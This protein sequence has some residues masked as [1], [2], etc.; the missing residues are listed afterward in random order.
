MTNLQCQSVPVYVS[1]MMYVHLKGCINHMH[2]VW[3]MG[4]QT[5]DDC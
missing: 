4:I 1:Y 5:C 2:F 3:H